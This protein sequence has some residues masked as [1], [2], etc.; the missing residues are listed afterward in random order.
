MQLFYKEYGEG[1]P[2]IIAH[3]LLGSSGNWHT[4][5]SRAFSKE[6]S[7][8]TVDLRNHGQSPHHPRMDYHSMSEDVAA[9]IEEHQ[10]APT[11][12][13]GH[14]MGGKVMMQLALSRPEL[15]DRLIVVDVAPRAYEDRHEAILDA[16]QAI[17]PDSF[18]SREEVDRE[19]EKRIPSYPVRQFLL[20]N[21]RYTPEEGYSWQMNLEAINGSYDDIAGPVTAKGV[22]TGLALFVRGGSSDYLLPEDEEEIRRSFPKARFETIEGAGHWVH[23]ETPDRFAATVTDFLND[24][25]D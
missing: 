8:F 23:A 2:L 19:L 18:S 24:Q 22:F 7:V 25:S 1:K 4:L 11:N 12:V 6:G 9:F 15:V 20:K 17:D 3:G 13:L 16:L 5:A 14:S 10:L 21:L